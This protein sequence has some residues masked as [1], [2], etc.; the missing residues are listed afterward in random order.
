MVVFPTPLFVPAMTTRGRSNAAI[1]LSL[2][3]IMVLR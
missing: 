2:L 3:A 1:Y